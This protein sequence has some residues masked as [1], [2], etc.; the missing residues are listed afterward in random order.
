MRSGVALGPMCSNV[1]SV[2]ATLWVKTAVP[3]QVIF[4]VFHD[5]A[6]NSIFETHRVASSAALSYVASATFENLQSNTTYFYRVCVRNDDL[7][8]PGPDGGF[9]SN[10]AFTSQPEHDDNA[11]LSFCTVGAPAEKASTTD[12]PSANPWTATCD[13]IVS[14]KPML[15]VVSGGVLPRTSVRSIKTTVSAQDKVNIFSR[16]YAKQL[17]DIA[18]RRLL[19]SQVVLF[20]LNDDSNGSAMALRTEET[21]ME[22]KKEET[23][24]AAKKSKK[25]KRQGLD[26]AERKLDEDPRGDITP[27]MMARKLH[28]PLE[29]EDVMTRHT[30]SR[31]RYGRRADFFLLDTRGGVLGKTQTAWLNR[32]LAASGCTWKFIVVQSM[33]SF[34]TQP[35]PPPG[36]K[37]SNGRRSSKDK[38]KQSKSDSKDGVEVGTGDKAVQQNEVAGA[39]KSAEGY[40]TVADTIDFI[41]SEGIT[42]VVFLTSDEQQLSVIRC[43]PKLTAEQLEAGQPAPLIH[44]FGIG[45]LGPSNQ[46]AASVI[47]ARK[48]A[49]LKPLRPEFLISQ[50]A[51]VPSGGATFGKVDVSAGGSLTY[52]VHDDSGATLHSLTIESSW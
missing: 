39:D 22:E 6:Y 24:K 14:A 9:F 52:T 51:E 40:I 42:G 36:S 3:G 34:E 10:G 27:A 46:I 45:P 44:S 17:G 37:G 31:S 21:A 19:S 5:E 1:S 49:V 13:S 32:E 18:I 23:P 7:Q 28:L 20:G 11:S 29:V 35:A 2:S 26:P 50:S 43:S 4:E 48:N 33:V 41:V 15:V 30:Y 47:P 25:G 16:L 12:P 38:K 8:M